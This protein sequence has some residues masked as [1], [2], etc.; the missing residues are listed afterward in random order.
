MLPQRTRGVRRLNTFAVAV[1]RAT[2]I[3]QARTDRAVAVTLAKGSGA[4]LTGLYGEACEEQRSNPNRWRAHVAL[5]GDR[6]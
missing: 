1:R 3:R 6:N 5:D 2:C 4:V